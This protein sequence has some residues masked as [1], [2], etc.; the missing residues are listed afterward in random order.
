MGWDRVSWDGMGQF[1]AGQNGMGKDGMGQFRAGQNGL[2]KDGM[3]QGTMGQNT[4]QDGLDC[5]GI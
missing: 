5:D 3:G 1:R 4:G 2:G